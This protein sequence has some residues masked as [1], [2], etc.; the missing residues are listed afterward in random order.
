L[1]VLTFSIRSLSSVSCFSRTRRAFRSSVSLSS[2]RT[3]YAETA[4]STRLRIASQ[5]DP[6]EECEH[7]EPRDRREFGRALGASGFCGA[8]SQNLNRRAHTLGPRPSGAF[9]SSLRLASPSSSISRVVAQSA[10][11]S[12]T[13]PSYSSRLMIRER[14]SR[15]F[16]LLPF[17]LA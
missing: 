16:R 15:C 7:R 14:N 10:C 5:P 17:G 1:G 9:A 4:E 8:L 12:V 6:S 3:I 11:Y 13:H 2:S